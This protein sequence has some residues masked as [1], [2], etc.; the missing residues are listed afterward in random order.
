MLAIKFLNLILKME[1][2]IQHTYTVSFIQN[3]IIELLY[4]DISSSILCR[5]GPT[6]LCSVIVSSIMDSANIKQLC[7]LI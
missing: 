3:E 4:E 1:I 6:K 7:L 2:V 5:L